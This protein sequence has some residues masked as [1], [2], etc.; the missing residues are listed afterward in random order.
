MFLTPNFLQKQ[1][2]ILKKINAKYLY[3]INDY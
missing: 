3:L 2:E 1:V